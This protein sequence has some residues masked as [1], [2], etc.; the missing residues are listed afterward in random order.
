MLQID[1]PALPHASDFGNALHKEH[2]ANMN[3]ADSVLLSTS[4]AR[5]VPALALYQ[6]DIAGNTGTLI[7]LSACMGNEIHIIGPAGFRHDDSAL[8]RAGM[9]YN[10]L[11]AIFRHDDYSSFSKFRH[12]H[13]RRLVLLTTK[14]DLPYTRF[15]FEPSDIL[16]LGR[17]SSGV[18]G[19]V[20]DTCDHHVTIPMQGAARSINQ[21]VAGAMV[22]GEAM[23]QVV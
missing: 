1:L 21:A 23:R 9:D 14:T 4:P 10:D 2:G 16:L 11:A 7:R 20:R 6:P 5:P 19:S 13:A 18:P 17:E 12:D 15:R 8:R 22:L 3:S